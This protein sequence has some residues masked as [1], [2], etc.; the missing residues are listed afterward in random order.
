[1]TPVIEARHLCKDFVRGAQH[2]TLKRLFMALG[3]GKK[4]YKRALIDVSLAIAPGESVAL[5]GRNGSGKSTLLSLIGRIYRPTSGELIVRKRVAPLLE[6]GAGFHHELT[7]RQNVELNGVILGLTR[8]QVAERFEA[9]VEFS[10]LR[11]SI[12]EHVRNY[13]S[14][15]LMRLGFAVACHTDAEILLVDEILAPADEEFQDKCYAKIAEFQREGRTTLFVSHD[16]DSVRRVA[17]RAVWL[18]QGRVRADGPVEPVLQQ[19]LAEA[20][21]QG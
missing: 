5:I 9:I 3:R 19:Y 16:A 10:E 8:A 21:H 12:D 2:G 17:R 15:M 1:M 7:G 14:G 13:S 6:L 18:D 20:H 11:P 4:E